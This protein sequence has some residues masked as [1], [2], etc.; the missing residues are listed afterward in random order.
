MLGVQTLYILFWQRVGIHVQNL[1]GLSYTIKTT[2]IFS[3]TSC[4][5]QYDSII[6]SFNTILNVNP[7]DSGKFTKHGILVTIV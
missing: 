6:Q 1:F 7:G 3:I 5:W 2:I 4:F